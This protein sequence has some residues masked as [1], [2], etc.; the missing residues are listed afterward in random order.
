VIDNQL[1][2]RNLPP[3]VIIEMA[4]RVRPQLEARA[5]VNQQARK[6]DQPGA[7]RLNSDDLSPV[8]TRQAIA[9]LAGSPRQNFRYVSGSLSQPY[10]LIVTTHGDSAFEI[11]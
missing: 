5:K 4:Q 3:F 9:D 6:G 8:D 11:V 10:R 7:T 2:R 1:G